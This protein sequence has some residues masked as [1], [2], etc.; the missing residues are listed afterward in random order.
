MVIN[1]V[2]KPATSPIM[3]SHLQY[4]AGCWLK[5]QER[6]IFADLTNKTPEIYITT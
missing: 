2:E 5:N 4:M 3:V 1:E 6:E